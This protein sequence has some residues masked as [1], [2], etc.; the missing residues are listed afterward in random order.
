MVLPLFYQ[1]LN[2]SALQALDIYQVSVNPQTGQYYLRPPRYAVF[3]V[4]IIFSLV[5]LLCCYLLFMFVPINFPT[6]R[7]HIKCEH[8]SRGYLIALNVSQ[9]LCCS[10]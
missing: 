9:N 1:F 6:T 10:D 4:I 7:K 5:K 2:D 3:L 8:K